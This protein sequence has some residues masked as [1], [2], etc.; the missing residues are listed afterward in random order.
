MSLGA[1][2]VTRNRH[3][4]EGLFVPQMFERSDHI[5]LEIVP[6]KTELLLIIHINL[7]LKSF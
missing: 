1:L 3:V 7:R 5:G 4:S 2:T 6:T